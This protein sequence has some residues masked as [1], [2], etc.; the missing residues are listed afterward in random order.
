MNRY[1]KVAWFNLIIIAA[2]I[3]VTATAIAVEFR[4]RG[5]S[6]VGL[7]GLGI[8]VLL[9]FTPIMFKKPRSG[10]G[11]VVDERDDFIVARANAFAW[12]AFWWLFVGSCF[13]LW[14]AI[15]PTNSVP[16]IALPL[17]P[18]AGGLFHK[19]ACSVAILLQYGR[20]GAYGRD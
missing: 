19:V 5:Y 10:G 4:L 14:L 11:A 7:F 12:M 15:G 9:K 13:L 1:Q 3:L 2:T 6:T 17:M 18:F 20:G 16:A 8:L